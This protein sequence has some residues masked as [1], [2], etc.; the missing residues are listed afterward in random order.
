MHYKMA[1]ERMLAEQPPPPGGM[2]SFQL[3]AGHDKFSTS[4][5]GL[6]KYESTIV[7]G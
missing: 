1:Q 7:L 2:T 3:M 5:V 4:T 6:N